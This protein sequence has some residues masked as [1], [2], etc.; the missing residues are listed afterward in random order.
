MAICEICN[1]RN[2][3][4][5][6]CPALQGEI[7]ARGIS[8]RMK[9]KTY[10][11]DFSLLESSQFLNGFQLEVRCKLIQDTLIKQTAGIDLQD[12]MKKHLT[13]RERQAIQFLLKGCRQQEIAGKMKISQARVNLLL[14]K[15]IRKLKVFFIGGL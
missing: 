6:I 11:V 13:K 2:I 5:E 9:D 10:V 8:P 14:K 1:K 4:R 12:L 7:S 3:C 15:S